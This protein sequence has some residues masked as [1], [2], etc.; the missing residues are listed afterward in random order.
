MEVLVKGVISRVRACVVVVVGCG[1]LEDPPRGHQAL[2]GDGA[3]VPTLPLLH[4]LDNK[5]APVTTRRKP[6]FTL[7]FKV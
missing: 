4:H 5:S 3:D 1:L 7:V 6:L 2:D